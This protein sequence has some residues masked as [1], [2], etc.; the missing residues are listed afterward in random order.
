MGHRGTIGDPE[1][2]SLIGPDRPQRLE[3]EGS[4]VPRNR[5]VDLLRVG[6]IALVALGHWLLTSLSYRQGHFVIGD[7]LG[8][9]RWARWLT[10]GFQV[11]PVFFLV[12]GFA[13]AI[14]WSAHRDE[15]WTAWLH[16][17]VR[18]LLWPTTLFVAT[19]LVVVTGCR[20][21]GVDP[22]DLSQGAWAVAIQLWF[23]P[24]YLL[25]L[26]GTP[27]MYAAHRRWGLWMPATLILGAGLVDALVLGL[28]WSWMGW[29]NYLLVWGAAHQLGFAWHDGG[30]THRRWMP[31]ALA[32]VGAGALAALVGLGPFPLSM[33]GVPGAPIDNAAPPTVALAALAVCQTGVVVAMAGRAA[34]LLTRPPLWRFVQ[35]ANASVMTIY[36]W[37]MVPVIPLAVALYPSRVVVEPS[38]GSASWWWMRLPWLAML[39]ALTV[40][41]VIAVGRLEYRGLA[42]TAPPR[43]ERRSTWMLLTGVGAVTFALFRF[44]IGGFDPA[45]RMPLVAIATYLSALMLIFGPGF[46]T[47][48]GA[49]AH[50]LAWHRDPEATPVR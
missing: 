47:H 21:V 11:M 46:S 5:Y 9:I 31:L 17:R 14:S 45:D 39:A 23:L 43:S 2:G 35:R 15:G 49:R 29:A 37:H 44:T 18:R 26:L 25:L 8:R 30:L 38:I 24:V 34:R 16:R 7:V 28:G 3:A 10:L 41:L 32:G 22:T 40:P 1:E 50:L 20:L 13:N 36:L 48:G 42:L 33:I 19:A 4:A 27:A 6:A 12:G